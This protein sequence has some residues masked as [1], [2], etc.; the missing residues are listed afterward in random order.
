MTSRISALTFDMNSKSEDFDGKFVDDRTFV[1]G[2][3]VESGPTISI[4]FKGK[5]SSRDY[6]T[7]VD[8]MREDS[9]RRRHSPIAPR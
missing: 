1:E 5:A 7:Q 3:Y 9:S 6:W 8:P 4:V 2:A